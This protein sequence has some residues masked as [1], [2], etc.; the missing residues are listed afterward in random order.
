M[1]GW[2]AITRDGVLL[3]E[4]NEDGSP[5]GQGRP[6]QMGLDNEL[7]TIA[8]SEYGH[9]VAV[10]LINGVIALDFE[11]LGVQNGTVEIEGVR[12]FLCICEETN[13]V[14]EYKERTA[15]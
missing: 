10:D 9:S 6:V 11:R 4:N 13:I 1:S 12:S 2:L 15:G 3:R 5:T 7:K 14:G 8:A